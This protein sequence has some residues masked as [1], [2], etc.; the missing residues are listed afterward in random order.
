ME[1]IPALEDIV[2]VL[3]HLIHEDCDEED[4]EFKKILQKE[5]LMDG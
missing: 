2:K 3:I 4:R 5:G 1:A